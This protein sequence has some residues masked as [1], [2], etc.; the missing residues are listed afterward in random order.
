MSQICRL[1]TNASWSFSLTN[2]GLLD[3]RFQGENDLSSFTSL[4]TLLKIPSLCLKTVTVWKTAY[5]IEI[6]LT[7]I[8]AMKL[9]KIDAMNCFI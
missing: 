2:T 4:L 9:T 3:Q 1:G 6:S 5:P 8:D 7:K